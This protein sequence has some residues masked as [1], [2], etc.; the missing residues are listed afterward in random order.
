ME[1][2]IEAFKQRN[3]NNNFTI[4][5]IVMGIA[6]KVEKIE[7]KVSCLDKKIGTIRTNQKYHWIAISALGA[8]VL[9]LFKHLFL[10]VL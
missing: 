6:S 2:D 8:A 4:K 7:E 10:P 1:E 9:F 5:E 3:G